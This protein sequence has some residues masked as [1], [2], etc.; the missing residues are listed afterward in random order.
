M[1]IRVL[2]ADDHAVFRHSVR[3]LLE[4]EP[5]IEIV[6]ETGSGIDTLR[7]LDDFEVDVLL[8]DIAMPGLSGAAVASEAL[9][10]HPALA[11]VVLTMHQ[12]ETYLRELLKTGVVGYVLK[13]STGTELVH[14]IRAAHR[15]DSFIDPALAKLVISHYVGKPPVDKPGRLQMLTA[16]E[17]EVCELLAYGHTNAEVAAKLFISDRTVE[18]HRTNV[19]TKLGLKTRAELVRFAIENGLLTLE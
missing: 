6:G 7:A 12:N 18:T 19:M 3:A 11:V 4:K 13:Q 14:A 16:R 10:C 1:P 5:D 8:L 17:R 9:R 2:I 15:G